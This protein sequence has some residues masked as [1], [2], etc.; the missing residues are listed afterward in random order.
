VSRAWPPAYDFNAPVKSQ[1][2]KAGGWNQYWDQ[3]AKGKKAADFPQE[4]YYD[5]SEDEDWPTALDAPPTPAYLDRFREEDFC[6][7]TTPLAARDKVQ[8]KGE[9]WTVVSATGTI[10]TAGDEYIIEHTLEA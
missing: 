2:D 6:Y 8:H 3:T 9:M 7:S 5:S 1:K 10:T 4:E